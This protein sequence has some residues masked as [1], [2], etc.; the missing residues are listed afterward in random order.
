MAPADSGVTNSCAAC[1][2]TTRTS[3]PRSLRR[4]IR[5]SD[6]YA[7]IPPPMMRRMRLPCRL[8]PPLVF[9][10]SAGS[11]C[12]VEEADIEFALK[13]L[14]GGFETIEAG[15]MVEAEQAID[16]FAVPAEPPRKLRSRDA[17]LA[18]HD[19]ELR[20]EHGK[21][22]QLH[23]SVAAPRLHG[24]DG[25]RERFPITDPCGD[26]LL[27]GAGGGVLNFLLGLAEGRHL[28]ER[29]AGD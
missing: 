20:L 10:C 26:C 19:V 21:G 17:A 12:S 7:A 1:V 23:K 3:A 8:G 2:M 14:E 29:G 25:L 28:G 18:Q 16:L 4:R 11:L 24:R 13:R 22:R 5:S 27:D 6:L 9:I 15:R